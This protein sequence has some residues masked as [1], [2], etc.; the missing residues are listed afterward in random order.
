M[1]WFPR[2]PQ[3]PPEIY[4]SPSWSCVWTTHQIV[5]YGD[6]WRGK[7]DMPSSEA[8]SDWQ[9][10]ND[11]HG[12]RLVD[13]NMI[14]KNLDPKGEVLQGSSLTMVGHCRPIYVAE[15]SD[16]DFDHNFQEV[17][18]ATGGANKPGHRICMDEKP[19]FCDAV[20]SFA[21]DFQGVDR[22]YGRENVQEYLAVQI[23][24]ERKERWQKPKII[25]LVLAKAKDST[26]EAFRR[27]GLTDFDELADGA[28]V[29]KTLKLL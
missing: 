14:H 29:R 12:P 17:V 3:D 27:V 5:W 6:T 28:W 4:Q 23:V 16:S 2:W 18:D 7:E 8:M 9:L 1:A 19:N 11:S 22:E 15:V 21:A 25:A 10:W 20:C 13:H 24:R 26:E